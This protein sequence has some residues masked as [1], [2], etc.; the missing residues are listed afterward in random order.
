M[1]GDAKNNR[2][3]IHDFSFS[4]PPKLEEYDRL[5]VTL[6]DWVINHFGMMGGIAYCPVGKEYIEKH[7]FKDGY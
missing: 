5:E 2:F 6:R 7:F 1:F 4:N 3:I